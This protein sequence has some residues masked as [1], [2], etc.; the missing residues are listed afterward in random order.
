MTHDG[1][2]QHTAQLADLT[3]PPIDDRRVVTFTVATLPNPPPF[4]DTEGTTYLSIPQTNPYCPASYPDRLF[5]DI[6]PCRYIAS[7]KIAPGDGYRLDLTVVGNHLSG[8]IDISNGQTHGYGCILRMTG[9]NNNWSGWWDCFL[10]GTGPK[11][12]FTAVSSRV[13]GN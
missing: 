13:G 4:S 2:T 9:D 8:T 1:L 11:H 6:P 10:H 3:S 5:Q 7:Q 12:S